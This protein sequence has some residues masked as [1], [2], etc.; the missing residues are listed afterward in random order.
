MEVA[1][2]AGSPARK[3][4]AVQRPIQSKGFSFTGW[5]DDGCGVKENDGHC[6][7]LVSFLDCFRLHP[8]SCRFLG[9]TMA[10]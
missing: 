9:V 5:C 6:Q 4:M 2:M 1:E 8:Y 3:E 7:Q 10:R